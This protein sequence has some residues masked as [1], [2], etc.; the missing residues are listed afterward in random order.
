TRADGAGVDAFKV[1]ASVSALRLAC[2]CSPALS[3]ATGAA[4][5]SMTRVA[6]IG[7]A[8]SETTVPSSATFRR[9]KQLLDAENGAG[10]SSF[11]VLGL[12]TVR[13]NSAASPGKYVSRSAARMVFSS[14]VFSTGGTDG[15]PVGPAARALIVNVIVRMPG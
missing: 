10:T 9:A 1:A 12:R 13:V 14:F 3:T 15:W 6:Q 4:A 8:E 5:A 2:R 7:W 11:V